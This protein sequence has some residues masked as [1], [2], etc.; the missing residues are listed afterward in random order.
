MS[1]EKKILTIKIEL[2]GIEINKF[3]KLKK[4]YGMNSNASMIRIALGAC[5]RT[6]WESSK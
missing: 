5:Y 3:R 4:Y 1:E 6:M 2:K